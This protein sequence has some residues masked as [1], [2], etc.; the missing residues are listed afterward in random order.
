MDMRTA[1]GR[2]RVAV[3]AV[4]LLLASLPAC[5]EDGTPSAGPATTD[6]ATTDEAT[7]TASPS[8][9]PTGAPS[10]SPS[11][12]RPDERPDE[13]PEQDEAPFPADR[14]PDTAQH[15]GGRLSPVDLRFG[16]HDGYDRVVLDLAGDGLPGWHAE[17]VDV[18]RNQG[19]GD[20]ADVEGEA[21]LELMVRGAQYPTE[22]GAEPYRGPD[23]L[24][25]A[26]SGVVVEVHKGVLYE[27][28]QQLFVGV[29][30]EQPFR[31]FRLAGPPRVVIDV[32][33]P[34]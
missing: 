14:R 23:T 21:H 9:S 19:R 25:P 15:T 16:V 6:E 1:P 8:P 18:P 17:Y 20:R 33:H 31:V 4:A 30:S 28:Y 7:P 10:P 34:R 2:Q 22:P 5:S 3:G 29:R 13:R 12:E 32:Q 11:P 26:A 27:G 24:T